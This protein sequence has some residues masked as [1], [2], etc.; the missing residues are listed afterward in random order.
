MLASLHQVQSCQKISG[1]FFLCLTGGYC[2]TNFFSPLF[3]IRIAT[4]YSHLSSRISVYAAKGG[5]PLNK[6]VAGYGLY[7]RTVYGLYVPNDIQVV[8]PIIILDVW[9]V[10]LVRVSGAADCVHA[11]YIQMVLLPLLYYYLLVRMYVH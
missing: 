5:T 9:P 10:R 4:Y 3:F 2:L 1:E 7:S 11:Y 6:L 8:L